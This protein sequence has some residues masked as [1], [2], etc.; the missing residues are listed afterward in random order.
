MIINLSGV[1]PKKVEIGPEIITEVEPEIL[2]V[3]EEPQVTK[4]PYALPIPKATLYI[5]AA[6]LIWKII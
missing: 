4:K 5:I 3:K 1:E 2:E 6:K